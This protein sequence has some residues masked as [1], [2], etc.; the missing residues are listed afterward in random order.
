ASLN[1]VAHT[2]RWMR[3][4][5]ATAVATLGVVAGLAWWQASTTAPPLTP[6]AQPAG[7]AITAPLAALDRP[8][9]AV[10]AFTNL[11]DDP[12]QEYFSDGMADDILT[13]LSRFSGLLVIARNSSFVYKGKSV[14][15]KQIGRELG[16]KYI[17][18]GSVRRSAEQL[19]LTAQLI[20]T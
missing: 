4:A 5:L 17:L 10:L 6:L 15:V 18:E 3:P 19:R 14:D 20:E 16:V 1:A 12:Q 11:S 9:I 8:S 2:T 13:A 7:A